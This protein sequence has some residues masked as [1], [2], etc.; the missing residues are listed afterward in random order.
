MAIVDV[1][2]KGN[3]TNANNFYKYCFKEI[4]NSTSRIDGLLLKQFVGCISP[5]IKEVLFCFICYM[6]YGVGHFV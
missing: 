1:L 6:V 3:W 2:R 4:V 5:A